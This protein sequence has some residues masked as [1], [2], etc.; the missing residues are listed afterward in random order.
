MGRKPKLDEVTPEQHETFITALKLGLPP[1][2][3]SELIGQN[4]DTVRGWMAR[5][6]A[7]ADGDD[8]YRDFYREA[9][10]A[11]AGGAQNYWGKL[12]T[13]ID[14]SEPRDALKGVLWI[15]ERRYGMTLKAAEIDLA[16]DPTEA[17]SVTINI[18]PP[19]THDDG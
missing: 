18:I 2:L 10:Q 5:G 17:R 13:L 12:L 9:K 16:G 6:K 19:A 1:K 8:A 7:A 11:E 3:A 14:T 4:P 15:M